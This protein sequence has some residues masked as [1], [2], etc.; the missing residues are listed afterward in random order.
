M[1]K[2]KFV[3][4]VALMTLAA[5][6]S[7]QTA[8]KT[9]TPATW[10]TVWFQYNPSSTKSDY[11][12]YNNLKFTGLSLGYSKAFHV[13]QKLP[14]YVEGG[15]GVQYSY[16]K[17]TISA[18]ADETTTEYLTNKYRML[19][20][21]VPVQLL[22]KWDV[23]Y[24]KFSLLPYFGLNFRFNILAKQKKED[25]MMKAN[26]EIVDQK[27]A[28]IDCFDSGD[29]GKSDYTWNRFQVGWELGVKATYDSKYMIGFS[30][31]TDFNEI[32]KNTSI[33]TT[34]LQLGYMF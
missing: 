6:A 3:A 34:T 17:N 21:K 16:D 20:A 7:A 27:K 26:G 32:G 9:V 33:H 25:I 30:Y 14:L 12:Y 15:I 28:T 11:D 24:S 5:S 31:G 10:Q 4:L 2:M 23:P 18:K 22:Y 29:M 1:K 13:S 19:S 8:K